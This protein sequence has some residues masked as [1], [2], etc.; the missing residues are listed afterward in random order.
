MES[1]IIKRKCRTT[2]SVQTQDVAL[3]TCR[4]RWIIETD[5]ERE[6]NPFEHDDDDDDITW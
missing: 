4:M 1:F 2:R 5:G 6:G 3:N